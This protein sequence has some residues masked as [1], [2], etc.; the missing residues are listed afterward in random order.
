MIRTRTLGRQGLQ[1]SAVGLGCMGM[2]WSYGPPKDKK[3]MVSLIHAAVGRGVTFS[4]AST[5]TY[6]SKTS[7]AP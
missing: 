3:E 5:P 6:R 1:V 2:S 4:T 7:P